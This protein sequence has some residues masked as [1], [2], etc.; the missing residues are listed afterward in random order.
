MEAINCTYVVVRMCVTS[1]R[2]PIPRNEGLLGFAGYRIRC[3]SRETGMNAGHLVSCH[4]PTKA[5]E[6]PRAA[7]TV[8]QAAARVQLR[9]E[10]IGRGTSQPAVGP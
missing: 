1:A 3:E 7:T 5:H 4:V 9:F 6:V 8:T 10:P 2:A